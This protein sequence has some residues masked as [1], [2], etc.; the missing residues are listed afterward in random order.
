MGRE[1][2]SATCDL[3]RKDGKNGICSGA[4]GRFSTETDFYHLWGEAGSCSSTMPSP[5]P[6][7]QTPTAACSIRLSLAEKA[8]S[9]L[10]ASR[11]LTQPC[12]QGTGFKPR[13]STPQSRDRV[14]ERLLVKLVS[15]RAIKN[16]TKP[17]A[18]RMSFSQPRPFH[19]N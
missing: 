11:P 9:R 18:G 4:Q 5:N 14:R 12:A 10:L 13:S 2:R 17:T 3:K 1:R 8:T 15:A 7:G 6:R 19:V 16:R